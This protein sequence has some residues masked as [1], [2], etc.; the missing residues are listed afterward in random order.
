[1]TTTYSYD[2]YLSPF[3][4]RY[5]SDHMRS[6]WS[7]RHKRQLWRR[8]WVALAQ[9]QQR[10]GLVSEAQA[11]D[12]RAHMDAVDVDAAL[13]AEK[14]LRHD[15]MAEI[16]V[17]AS[18]C[19]IGGGIIHLGATSM[20]IEDNAEAL[21]L[22][23][24]LDSVLDQV[25][26]LLSQFATQIERWAD[27]ASMAF[28]HLQPAEPTTIGYRLAQYAQDILIDLGE[29]ARVRDAVR[30]KGI[31]GAVGTSASY[32]QLLIDTGMTPADLESR[33]MTALD[34]PAFTV[35]TQTYPRKQDYLIAAALASL[36]SSL[37]KFCFDL[38]LLQ[39]PPIGE[40]SEGFAA[41]QV[42]SSAMPFKRNPINAEKVDSLARMLAHL[43][44]VT[45]D[46]AS[47]SLLERTLDDNAN[48]REVL[49]TLFLATDEILTV[50]TKLISGL[51]IDQA[52][53]ERTLDRY[54]TF[55]ATERL[56][57]ELTKAGADRQ[58]MH[59]L[60]RDHSLAAWQSLA[61]GQPNPLI[62]SLCADATICAL[63]T[64]ATVRD[65]LTASH[66]IGDAPTRARALVAEINAAL[67]V[68]PSRPS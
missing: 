33:V 17:F 39:S 38:R 57:M 43:V 5:G 24:S 2:S 13:E 45:W 29:L 48:R 62:D 27:V 19:Q 25:R 35:A 46:N 21:R 12:L 30:G 32:A 54:G 60:L 18:Q 47:H 8:V 58:H 7:E 31:K 16:H 41:G 55:A 63:L 56:L 67:V 37:Y 28:T 49:P 40:W 6:I 36:A 26:G 3:T 15:L 11:A 66:Y 61:A 65:L 9:A 50:V 23:E 52:A 42:G 10:A 34:L 44:G 4:W 14:K 59:A 64:P 51:Q 22:R 1:M 68:S 20:D 53:V